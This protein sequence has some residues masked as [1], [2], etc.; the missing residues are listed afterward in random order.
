MKKQAT[1]KASP[2]KVAKKSIKKTAPKPAKKSAKKATP[3]A[4]KKKKVAP[5]KTTKPAPKKN[6][7]KKSPAKKPKNVVKKVVTTTTTTTTTTIL[8]PTETH[9][10]LILDESGSM[11]SVRESTFNGLNEQIQTI[12]NLVK[13]YPDQKYF[14]NIVK[15]SNNVSTLIENV[16]ASK[17]NLLNTNDY[18][19]NGMT[20]LYDAIGISVNNLKNRIQSRLDSGDASAL[21]VILTDGEENVSREYNASKIKSLIT[22]LETNKLWTFSFVGANQDAILTAKSLGVNTSNT[23]NYSSSVNGTKLAFA[24]MGASLRSRAAYSNAGL[25][26]ATTDNLM[27]NVVGTSVNIGEDADALNL[28]GIVT[29]EDLDKAAKDLKN[30]KSN[31]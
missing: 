3:N 12:Q 27:S 14:I 16:E 18:S 20:A 1:K 2:K 31:S 11:S 8:N 25:Y 21:V 7:P 5:K 15:F 28:T 30:K 26:E 22:D 9:Y 19:P 6:T 23:V 17:A 13:E 24:S 4:A 10:L 29:Q